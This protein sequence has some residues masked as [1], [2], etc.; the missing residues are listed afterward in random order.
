MGLYVRTLMGQGLDREE[1][2]RIAQRVDGM[3]PTFD[4][5][6]QVY[7]G[8]YGMFQ[9]QG[10]YW[11]RWNAR[12]R[13]AL[14]RRQERS[15]R[16]RGAWKPVI[17]RGP[18]GSTAMNV[19]SLEVYYRFLPINRLQVAPGV[20][21]DAEPGGGPADAVKPVGVQ[22]EGLAP[23]GAKPEGVNPEQGRRLP[24]PFAS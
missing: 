15:G 10:S 4:N 5:E 13:D 3:G 11:G 2:A 18:V 14:I 17:A 20:G 9:L 21:R 16:M 1:V 8:T 23:E 19:M 24:D 22:P 6:F 12:F 7:Y